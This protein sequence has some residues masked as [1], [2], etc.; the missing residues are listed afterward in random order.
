MNL[1]ATVLAHDYD[2]LDT[3]ELQAVRDYLINSLV[4]APHS[5]AIARRIAEVNDIL[6]SRI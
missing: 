3:T 1:S 5:S 4:Q 2:N 6:I